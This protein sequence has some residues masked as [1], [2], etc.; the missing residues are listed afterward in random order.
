M[1]P[2]TGRTFK[3]PPDW[4]A[5]MAEVSQPELPLSHQPEDCATPLFDLGL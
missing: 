2:A 5:G 3:R 1:V 4:K